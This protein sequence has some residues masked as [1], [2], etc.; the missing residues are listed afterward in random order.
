MIRQSFGLMIGLM[1]LAPVA[2]AQDMRCSGPVAVARD[3]Q[4]AQNNSFAGQVLLRD[5][6]VTGQTVGFGPGAG[7]ASEIILQDGVFHVARKTDNGIVVTTGTEPAKGAIFVVSADA[8]QWREPSSLPEVFDLSE[9]SETL[10]QWAKDQGCTGNLDFP[11]KITGHASS[12]D[13]SVEAK[14]E[15]A[16][17]TL[18][19]IDLTVVGVYSNHDKKAHFM[20]PGYNLHAHFVATKAKMAGHVVE[21]SLDEGAKLFVPV[22]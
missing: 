10:G 17:G 13:W 18:E 4:D 12:L 14:P 6:P 16:T 5:I 20:V 7:L 9:L 3:P 11:F 1:L 8:G 15:K 22:P 21:L 19:D 2:R